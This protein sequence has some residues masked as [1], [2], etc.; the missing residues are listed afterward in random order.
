[1]VNSPSKATVMHS[2]YRQSKEVFRETSDC[3]VC[4]LSDVNCNAFDEST[5]TVRTAPE[6]ASPA[7]GGK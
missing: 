5:I 7:I 3:N 2:F 1:M 6:R 4:I